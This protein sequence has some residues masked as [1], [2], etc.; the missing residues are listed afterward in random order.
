MKGMIGIL[1]SFMGKEI[2]QT[3]RDKRMRVAMF[4]TPLFQLLI[5]GLSLSTYTQNVKL[6]VVAR[7]DDRFTQ[8]LAERFYS[9]GWFVP[10]EQDGG[11]PA[12][13]VRSGRAEAV[14]IAP[15]GVSSRGL[16]RGEARFQFLVDSV[17]AGR[18]RTIESYA[19]SILRR[20]VREDGY[21]RRDLKMR[22]NL[23]T[24]FNPER[25]TSIYVIPG[26]LCI[27][28]FLSITGLTNISIARERE[29]GTIETL[30]A[31]PI[32]A[33][34]IVLGK[35]IPFVVVG[36]AQLCFGLLIAR[37]LGVPMRAPIWMICAATLAFLLATVS[38]SFLI[39]MRVKNQRQAVIA[40]L[41]YQF[42]CVQLSGILFPVENMPASIAW[43]SAVNPLPLSSRWRM[44]FT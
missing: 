10:I 39:S 38:I 11:D 21:D 30:F 22:F 24:F 18:A 41:I 17:N 19:L 35:T 14:L 3:F 7:P 36:M 2:A 4:Y 40:A 15:P 9:S 31:A 25:Q 16:A 43:L 27:L 32:S 44:A 26:T 29:M 13:W 37:L 28:M 33:W 8:R 42:P 12:D 20:A 6:A 34:E 5:Y 23:R 1:L